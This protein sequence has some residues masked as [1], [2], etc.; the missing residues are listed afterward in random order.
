MRRRVTS[1]HKDRLAAAG[2]ENNPDYRG[3]RSWFKVI[4]SDLKCDCQVEIIATKAPQ[5]R[6][7][8]ALRIATIDGVATEAP[9]YVPVA[10]PSAAPPDIADFGNRKPLPVVL[11]LTCQLARLAVAAWVIWM[12]VLYTNLWSHKSELLRIYGE[13]SGHELGPISPWQQVAGYSTTLL[14]TLVSSVFV[15]K[16]WKM[17]DYYIAGRIFD[18]QAVAAFRAMARMAVV[19]LVVEFVMRFVGCAIVTKG[20]FAFWFMPGDPLH[21]AIV[22][23]ILTQAEIFSAG[24]A[25]ADEHSQII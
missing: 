23:G 17:F 14:T 22:L 3:R 12:F 5:S 20:A 25:I 24:A 1:D 19:M 8:E 6:P 18:R 21:S 2:R 15:V 11:I 10:A 16:N 4:E 7:S 9:V 13:A